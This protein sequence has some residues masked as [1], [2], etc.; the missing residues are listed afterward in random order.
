MREENPSLE[1]FC[2][3]QNSALMETLLKMFEKTLNKLVLCLEEQKYSIVIAPKLFESHYLIMTEL[4]KDLN[5]TIDLQYQI[6]ENK[7]DNSMTEIGI[8][9]SDYDTLLKT[10]K[11][12]Q[13]YTKFQ[14][15]LIKGKA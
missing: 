6:K 2:N 8:L 4:A 7:E 5:K 13:L 10:I 14:T 3:T 12:I 1:S 11:D 9:S 15:S